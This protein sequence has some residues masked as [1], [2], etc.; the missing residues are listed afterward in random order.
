MSRWIPALATTSFLGVITPILAVSAGAA[1]AGSAAAATVSAAVTPQATKADRIFSKNKKTGKV[2]ADTGVVEEANLSGVKYV[3]RGDKNESVKADAVVQ[4][5]WG[6]V[7]TSFTDGETYAKRGEWEQA[8]ASFQSAAADSDAREPVR[9]AARMRSLESMMQWGAT[10]RARFADAIA[11]AD[12]FMSDHSTDW[13]IPAVRALKARATWLSGDAAAAR[14][15][16]RALY[17]AGKDGADGFS[18]LMVAE[19]AL[20]GARAALE[21][22]ETSTARELFDTA[23]SA[24]AAIDSPDPEVMA[25]AAGG[26][27][28]ARLAAAESL[29][30]KDDFDGA[31]RAFESAID[32][33]STS[34]GMGAARLGLGRA[35][36]GKGETEEAQIQLGWVAGLDH[37][38]ADRR[39][40]ALLA[41]GEALSGVPE[42]ASIGKAALQRVKDEFG[43]TP[44]GARAVELLS[45]M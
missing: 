2:E 37:T 18:P 15:G 35:L 44:S 21:S 6:T 16:Y 31:A 38:S 4:I 23:A 1:L 14:D 12:R 19:A 34:A 41:L 32:D 7:P 13:Q 20:N 5:Q 26:A 25:R 10:D 39:A 9:A 42:S 43:A 24:F 30:A 33:V 29:L 17:E 28:V 27:E 3:S 45:G 11:E 22:P 8:V 36:L 40:A